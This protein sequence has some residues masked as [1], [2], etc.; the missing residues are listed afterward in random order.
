MK[1]ELK[2]R[3]VV[4]FT[5]LL[6]LSS[7][8]PSCSLS[9]DTSRGNAVSSP[10]ENTS[11]NQ[12]QQAAPLSPLPPPTGCVNDYANVFEPESKKR[13]ESFLAELREK[14]D[15]EFAVV[16]VETTAGPGVLMR[17]LRACSLL[18]RLSR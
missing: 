8:C 15:I 12:S 13:L 1:T 17:L 5:T 18:R 16:T 14:S 9:A 3:H 2:S 4:A 11:S 10:P 7:V 6:L